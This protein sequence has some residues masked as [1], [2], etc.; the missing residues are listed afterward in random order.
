MDESHGMTDSEASRLKSG[1][2]IVAHGI[3]RRAYR[4]P[5]TAC[6]NL[7]T[8]VMASITA[9]VGAPPPPDQTPFAPLDSLH[10]NGESVV[11]LYA[12]P[13]PGIESIAIHAWFVVKHA[14]SAEFHRWEVWVTAAD[15]YGYVRMDLFPP[16]G[17]L[18]A[19][20]AYV[21]AE[22]TG[23][24]SEPVIMFIETRSSDYPCRGRFDLVWGPNSSTYVQWIL[25]GAGWGVVLPPSAIGKDVPANCS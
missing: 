8:V 14:D 19:G 5:R 21:L 10:Q 13:L 11:R 12:A 24:E 18:G 3:S 17:D 2:G 15:P 9:C 22:L 6:F 1:A 23:A 16:E 4:L 25:S 7:A 20:S